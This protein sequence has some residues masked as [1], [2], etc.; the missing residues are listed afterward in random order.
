VDNR[1][2]D[3][4]DVDIKSLLF[5]KDDRR[6]QKGDSWGKIRG[7]EAEPDEDSVCCLVTEAEAGVSYVADKNRRKLVIRGY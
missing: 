2:N 1:S 3:G 5:R 4:S 7:S 6:R